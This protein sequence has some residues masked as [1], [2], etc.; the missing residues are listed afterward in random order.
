MNRDAIIAAATP[1]PVAHGL[2][3]QNYEYYTEEMPRDYNILLRD[4][5]IVGQHSSVSSPESCGY[6]DGSRAGQ[7]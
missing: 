3:A 5:L 4:R 6:G 1:S 7:L 2:R